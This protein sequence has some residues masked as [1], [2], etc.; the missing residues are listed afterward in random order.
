MRGG[1]SKK[2]NW[3]TSIKN[4][5][6]EQL[7]GFMML[8]I[9]DIECGSGDVFIELMFNCVSGELTGLKQVSKSDHF[10]RGVWHSVV[11]SLAGDITLGVWIYVCV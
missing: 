6:D 3:R 2:K 9:T 4:D 8:S 7:R 10:T 5:L 1:S 11:V